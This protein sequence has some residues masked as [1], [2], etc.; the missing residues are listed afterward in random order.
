MGL[1]GKFSQSGFRGQVEG[2]ILDC[3]EQKAEKALSEE[4]QVMTEATRGECI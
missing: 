2:Q 3:Q 4:D 1:T